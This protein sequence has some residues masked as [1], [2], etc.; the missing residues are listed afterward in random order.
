[1]R[2]RTSCWNTPSIALVTAT[3]FCFST[4]RMDMHRWDASMT[5]AD[6]ERPDLLADGLGDLIGEPLLH[7][8]PAGER[9]SRA[10]G[11]C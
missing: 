2:V 8:E 5:M 9:I 7:L 3:E 6:A 10:A 11:S 4:P 1:M